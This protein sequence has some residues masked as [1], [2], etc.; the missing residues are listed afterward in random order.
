MNKVVDQ[1]IEQ[2]LNEKPLSLKSL[3]GTL[4]SPRTLPHVFLISV[5]CT[6]LH[7]MVKSGMKEFAAMGFIALGLGYLVTALLSG[8]E[9]IYTHTSLPEQKG[10]ALK[11]VRLLTNFR[12]CII[13]LGISAFI[14]LILKL[15][16]NE[17]GAGNLAI[18]LAGLFVVWSVGQARSFRTGVNGWLS[19]G[20]AEAKL[21]SSRPI[22]SAIVQV[23]L[24]QSAAALLIWLATFVD[25]KQSI[26]F[27]SALTSGWLFMLVSIAVQ[28]LML[29]WTREQRGRAGEEK[30]LATFSFKWMVIAQLFVTWHLLSIYRRWWMNPSDIATLV[31]EAIL[32]VITVLLAIWALTSKS[33]KKEKSILTERSAL[34]MGIAFGYAYAGSVSMLTVTFSDIRGVMMLGHTLTVLTILMLIK[35]T[36]LTTINTQPA[37]LGEV[38]PKSKEENDES[39]PGDDSS[40]D[41]NSQEEEKEEIEASTE[42]DSWQEEAVD[43]EQPPDA[44]DSEVDWI[45]EEETPNSESNEGETEAIEPAENDDIEL[46]KDDDV[47]AIEDDDVEAIEDDDVELIEDDGED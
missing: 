28:V 33:V 4:L 46:I 29:W 35:P 10:D 31:E 20:L 11:V 5:L 44:I 13:P 36:L 37:P 45:E 12:I 16:L 39:E 23:I 1:V 38:K 34:P 3:I 19:A 7:T 25:Q 9:W 17:D 14:Y 21:H 40:E 41:D 47:E 26:S 42:D 30:G 6:V 43:W 2:S 32:M 22:L 15:V 18:I 8:T 27:A 24:I